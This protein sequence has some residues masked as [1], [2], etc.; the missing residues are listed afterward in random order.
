MI[1]AGA[2]RAS[3]DYDEESK[4]STRVLAAA[5][6]V[7]TLALGV[8]PGTAWANKPVYNFSG[9]VTTV[10]IGQSITVNGRTYR[11]ETGSPA[12]RQVNDIIRGERVQVIL[13]APTDSRSAQVVAIHAARGR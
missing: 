9:E 1:A 3:Y 13:D 6:A 2:P 11:I 8:A 4:M 7:A 5:V 12:E 10:P